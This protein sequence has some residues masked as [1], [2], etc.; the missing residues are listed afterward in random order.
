MFTK[1]WYKAIAVQMTEKYR[2]YTNCS[3]ESQSAYATY[4]QYFTKLG[5]TSNGAYTPRLA[6]VCTSLNSYGGVI[7]GTGTT[8]PTVD[9]YCLS[10]S[11]ITTITATAS[12]SIEH[13]ENGFTA[14]ATYMLTN[15]GDNDI[16]IG[17]VGIIASLFSN[18]STDSRYKTLLERSVLDTPVTIRSGGIGQVTYTIRMNYP[19]A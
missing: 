9:D 5:A 7:F 16:T 19:T 11:L 2:S 18:T 8:A 17:E 3:G 13:D 4:A 14:T 10:G 12:V 6:N 1:N 15:T